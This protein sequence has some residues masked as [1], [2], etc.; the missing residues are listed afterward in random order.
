M[1]MGGEAA[2]ECFHLSYR[3]DTDLHRRI[4]LKAKV[5]ATPYPMNTVRL[6][7]ADFITSIS[8]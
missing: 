6:L 5:A 1:A 3:I 7:L 8:F 2:A 4:G